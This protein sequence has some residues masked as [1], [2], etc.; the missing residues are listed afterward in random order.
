MSDMSVFAMGALDV[1]FPDLPFLFV[2]ALTQKCVPF[3]NTELWH[4]T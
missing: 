2:L 4:R 1:Y 3:G